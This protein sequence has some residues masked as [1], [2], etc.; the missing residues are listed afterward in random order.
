MSNIYD[1]LKDISSWHKYYPLDCQYYLFN[2]NII[3]AA[4]KIVD[5]YYQM[6][7]ARM[8]LH[9]Y[10]DYEKYSMVA[11]DE[12]SVLNLKK[13]FLENALLYYNFSV[14]YLWQVLWLYY[15]NSGTKNEMATNELYQKKM[16]DCGFDSLL[17]GLTVIKE[18]K[19][20]EILKNNF[21]DRNT[22]YMDIRYKYNYLK[23]RAVFHTPGLGM[24]DG[25][26]LF[27]LP[28][29]VT[30]EN[31]KGELLSYRIPLITREA[32]KL[33]DLKLKLINFDK[34]FVNVCE[35]LFGVIIP[36]NYLSTK[37][38]PVEVASKYTIEHLEELKK[39][40]QIHQGIVSREE[41]F[42][43]KKGI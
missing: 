35:Y 7:N 43:I 6:C 5:L 1:D 37:S 24:N 42:I 4:C 16:K 20:V 40:E 3:F 25:K 33:E 32:V 28:V 30:H 29:E 36:I 10:C 19:I 11:D 8:S 26:S 31:G 17:C 18:N 23:H 2:T 9:F 34:Q 27:P 13:Y 14:D 21:T 22:L 15:D 39:Y 38:V 41:C 12:V